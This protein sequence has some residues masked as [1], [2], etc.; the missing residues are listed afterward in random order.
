MNKC[1]MRNLIKDNSGFTLIELVVVIAILGI[2]ISIAVPKLNKS[3]DAAE[4]VALDATIQTLNSA[5]GIY[6]LDHS[7]YTV[8]VDTDSALESVGEYIK[9]FDKVEKKYG[10]KVEWND[11]EE[12][13]EKAE[14]PE[15][16][17]TSEN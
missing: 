3:K 8:P 7:D 11:K 17:E 10:D 12:V 15:P 16:P 5:Y 2:L 6:I 13:F 4:K 14:A 1:K 9:D